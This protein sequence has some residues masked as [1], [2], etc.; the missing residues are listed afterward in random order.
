MSQ[1][2]SQSRSHELRATHHLATYAADLFER[3]VQIVVRLQF[4]LKLL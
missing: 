3:F 1:L 4:K 2:E